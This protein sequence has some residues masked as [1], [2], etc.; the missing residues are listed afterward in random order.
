MKA[1]P[2]PKAKSKKS[3]TVSLSPTT[4]KQWQIESDAQTLKRAMEVKGD[5]SRLKL[6]QEYC[7]KEAEALKQV[8][9]MK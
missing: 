8:S 5:P 2:K 3:S 6:A 1:K 7:T 9:K 4:D